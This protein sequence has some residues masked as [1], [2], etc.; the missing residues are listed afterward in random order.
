MLLRNW[1]SVLSIALLCAI[2]SVS[3]ADTVYDATGTFNDVGGPT[4]GGT[5]TISDAGVVTAA[6]LTLDGISFININSSNAPI[7]FFNYTNTYVYSVTNPTDYIHLAVYDFGT[8]CSL[9]NE[10]CMVTIPDLGSFG[11]F[12]SAF[13]ASPTL[14]LNLLSGSA[15]PELAPSATP[16]PSSLALLGT[17]LLGLAGAA[18]RKFGKV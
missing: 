18:R 1:A 6:D 8:V 7:A 2:P 14:Q 13:V 16:E 15:T 12:S 3:R 17:G 9:G 4:L 10:P 11:D 5:Y